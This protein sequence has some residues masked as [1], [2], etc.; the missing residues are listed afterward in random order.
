MLGKVLTIYIE[1]ISKK[2]KKILKSDDGE[3]KLGQVFKNLEKQITKKRKEMRTTE[4]RCHPIFP[5]TFFQAIYPPSIRDNS[6]LG[7]WF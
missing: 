3:Q 1:P 7:K 5:S 6:W 2:Y 4:R